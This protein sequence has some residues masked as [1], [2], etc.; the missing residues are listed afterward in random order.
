M[1]KKRR[2][3]SKELEKE[4]ATAKRDVELISAK[5]NDI[6][7]DDIQAEYQ[8]AFQPVKFQYHFIF[9]LYKTDGLTP[10][11]EKA[12]T[13]YKEYLHKFNSEYET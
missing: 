2:K 12:F 6:Y 1:P 13:L 7:D 3:L 8:A 11:S 5:I 4:L 9:N 10:E